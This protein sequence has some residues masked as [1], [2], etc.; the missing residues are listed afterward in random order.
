MVYEDAEKLYSEV[1]KDGHQMIQKA[2]DSLIGPST[3]SSKD[4]IALNTIPMPRCE[5]VKVPLVGASPST[6]DRFD[7]VTHNGKCGYGLYRSN[8]MTL[9]QVQTSPKLQNSVSGMPLVEC[10]S[11]CLLP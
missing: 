11:A 4:M 6:V 2:L 3:S 9:G 8:G 5:V 10:I 1:A 7:Q